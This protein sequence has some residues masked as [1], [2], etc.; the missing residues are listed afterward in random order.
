MADHLSRIPN[1]PIEEEPMN[2]D[3]SDEHILVI[4]KE[5]WYA[6]IVSYL[7][8]RQVPSEWMKRDRYR[9]FPRYG[10]SFGK[11]L[12]FSNTVLT[13]LSNDVY[14]RKSIRVY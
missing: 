6:D 1:A 9:F 2:E 8:T 14:Q 10:S 7:A 11:S 5:P 13:K 4:F 3:F 12:T